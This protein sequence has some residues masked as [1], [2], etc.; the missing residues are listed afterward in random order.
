MSDNQTRDEWLELSIIANDAA[1]LGTGVF[2]MQAGAG[3]DFMKD[4]TYDAM[5]SKADSDSY[6]AFA[7]VPHVVAT[8]AEIQLNPCSG[9]CN[10]TCKRP[11][12]LCDLSI[13]YCK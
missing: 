2:L 11:G 9:R 12:C 7:W 3:K 13:G 5:L 6:Y 10:K 4:V 8:L 1:A